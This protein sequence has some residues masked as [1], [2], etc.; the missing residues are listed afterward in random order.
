MLWPTCRGSSLSNALS[1]H[2]KVFSRTIAS[3]S[4]AGDRAAALKYP[5][6][7]GRLHGTLLHRREEGQ[8]RPHLPH[9]RHRGGI[10]CRGAADRLRP[11]SFVEL[12]DAFGVNVPTMT[13]IMI[14][15]SKWLTRWGLLVNGR[16]G[17]PR[18][19]CVRLRPDPGGPGLQVDAV[20]LKAPVLAG[21]SCC[22]NW[23]GPADD[24]RSSSRWASPSP[25]S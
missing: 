17:R 24:F 3:P 21:F 15:T 5:Q 4:P 20:M 2:P 6:A 10:C 22:R 12:Y 19:R 25:R 16:H 14:G 7:D 18:R 9:P 11:A 23:R 8:E 13:K 1:K